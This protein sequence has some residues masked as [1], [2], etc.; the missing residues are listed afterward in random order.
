MDVAEIIDV[1]ANWGVCVEWQEE[2]EWGTKRLGGNV[3][4]KEA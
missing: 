4:F 2:I 3:S 1:N